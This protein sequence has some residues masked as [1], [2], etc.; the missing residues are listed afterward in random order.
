MVNS[1]DV[2]ATPAATGTVTFTNMASNTVNLMRACMV[3]QTVAPGASRTLT[4]SG[5][6]KVWIAPQGFKYNCNLDCLDCFYISAIVAGSGAVV[7]G[8]GYGHNT[9]VK[10]H[11]GVSSLV[12]HA[13]REDTKKVDEATCST[14]ACAFEHIIAGFHTSV[15][16]HGG[17]APPQ[18]P[19]TPATPAPP[20]PVTP[21]PPVP[22][23]GMSCNAFCNSLNNDN[24]KFSYDQLVVYDPTCVKGGIGCNAKGASQT[25]RYC[26][27]RSRAG[28][29]GTTHC[30]PCA[31]AEQ[32][33][34]GCIGPSIVMSNSSRILI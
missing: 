24:D 15:V 12:L 22:A 33:L 5:N 32:G 18:P 8:I 23:V 25:C 3:L 26:T 14:G 31:C 13:T 4:I 17:Q 21:A 16:L 19:P 2:V 28:S 7:T 6:N 29:H 30:P 20:V 1:T 27:W 34:N 9:P 11:D 10:V